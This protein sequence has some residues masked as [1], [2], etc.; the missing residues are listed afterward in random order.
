MFLRQLDYLVALSRERHFGRAAAACNVSQPALSGAITNIEHELGI[1]LVRRGQNFE[2]FTPDG[3]RVLAWAQRVLADCEGLRQVAR[4]ARDPE[5][6]PVGLLRVGALPATHP[7]MSLL[8]HG[9]LELYP[10]MRHQVF[11]LSEDQVFRRMTDFE[12]DAGLIYMEENLPADM[13]A[14]PMFRER[15]VLIGRDDRKLPDGEIDWRE[16][17]RLALCLLTPDMQC[18][19]GIDAAFGRAGVKATPQVETDSIM[20]LY[21]HVRCAGLYSIVPH[22]VLCMAEMNE[23]V[24][25]VPLTPELNL[26]IG[27]V[28]ARREPRTPLI[29]AAVAAFQACDLQ[30]HVDA[31]L[32]A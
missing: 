29:E 7:L 9:C 20:A 15:Y 10:K 16:A 24:T 6:G 5:G 17:A 2:G 32:R 14:L 18:R 28:L 8:I 4:A 13:V 3:E 21:A 31:L 30:T 25:A 19:R 23:E 12:L 26:D 27:L 1:L 22:S 11:T